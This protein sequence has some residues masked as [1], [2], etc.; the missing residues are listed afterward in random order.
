MLLTDVDSLRNK[1]TRPS[2]TDFVVYAGAATNRS[3][4]PFPSMSAAQIVAPK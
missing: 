2:L 3:S 4:L 1:S